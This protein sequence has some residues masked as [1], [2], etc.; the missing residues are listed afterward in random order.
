MSHPDQNWVIIFAKRPC[1]GRVKTRLSAL[2]G[3]E[4]AC[5]LYEALLA[6]TTLAVGRLA[7]ARRVIACDPPEEHPWFV[8]TFGDRFDFISQAPGD[9]GLRL[10]DSFNQAFARGARRVVIVGSD[11]PTLTDSCVA[12][13]FHRLDTSD[14]VLGPADDGGYYLIGLNRPAPE[15][16][17]RID[18]STSAVLA[19]TLERARA[20]RLRVSHLAQDCDVDDEPSL[21]KL[22]LRLLDAPPAVAPNTRSLLNELQPTLALQ[23]TVACK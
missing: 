20:G 3:P 14:L 23:E 18:W 2:L 12:E 5:R 1:P 6:D 9:L 19:Q 22:A 4:R 16:F 21:R 17:S 10:C 7:D 11:L 13:A 15:L 8:S